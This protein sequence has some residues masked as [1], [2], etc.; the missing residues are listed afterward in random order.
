MSRIFLLPPRHSWEKEKG[1]FWLRV[2]GGTAPFFLLYPLDGKYLFIS[3]DLTTGRRRELSFC[4][5][6]PK[7]IFLLVKNLEKKKKKK[8]LLGHFDSSSPLSLSVGWS[9]AD[10]IVQYRQRM[11][12]GQWLMTAP[13]LLFFNPPPQTLSLLYTKKKRDVLDY[14]SVNV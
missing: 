9:R 6:C 12:N 5:V 13:L 7:F 8:F 14:N 1:F 3:I 2:E 4:R 11:G 10:N